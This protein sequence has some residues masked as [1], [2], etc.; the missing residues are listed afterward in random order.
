M[1]GPLSQSSPCSQGDMASPVFGST[2]LASTPAISFPV[3]PARLVSSGPIVRQIAAVD[4]VS[5]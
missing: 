4:S 2:I 1:E 3:V 5:P